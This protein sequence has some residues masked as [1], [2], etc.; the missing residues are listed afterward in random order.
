VDGRDGRFLAPMSGALDCFFPG[1]LALEGDLIRARSTLEGCWSMQERYGLL[2]DSFEVESGQVIAANHELRPELVESLF[3]LHRFTGDPI[4][5]ERGRAVLET[6][7]RR[8]RVEDGYTVL[9][10]VRSGAQGD[11]M[12]S[13]FLAETLKYLYLLFEDHDVVPLDAWVFNTEAHP[14]PIAR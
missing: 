14:L 6:L 8:C 11:G 3:Y 12:P 13:F 9:S 7:V 5:R 1:L 2:P 10:D 4:Y